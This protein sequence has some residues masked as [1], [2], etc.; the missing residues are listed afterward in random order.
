[1]VM[2]RFL[3]PKNDFAF[4]KI[5]G[6]EKNKEILIHFL[7]DILGFTK[8]QKIGSVTF[9]SPLQDPEA[10]AKKQS[11]VDVL[12]QDQTGRKFIIEMQVARVA[13]F[14]E[15]AQYYAARAYIS[16]MKVGGAYEDLAEVIFVAIMDH[17]IFPDKR[18]Y[19]SDH[20]IRDAKSNERD[21]DKLRFVFIEL[22]KFTKAIDELSSMVDKWYY[23]L[24]NAPETT[25]EEVEKLVDS[26]QIIKEAYTALNS[27][28]WN[29]KELLAYDQEMKSELDASAILK[30]S[31]IDGIAEGRAEGK[32][33]GKAEG[34]KTKA[35]EIAKKLK[36][37]KMPLETI[38]SITGLPL[39]ELENLM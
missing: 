27:F 1:M 36:A 7:N 19:Q 6:T 5:F 14:K 9:I 28:Y 4:K 35:L 29:D 21:L 2:P 16:Q 30:Q 11:I 12:C 22:P 25:P 13:G 3:D 20:T 17:V 37:S 10:L 34:E 31:R 33:E 15:R 26:D 23:F 38:Q 39:A 32:A 8:Q 18:C 24:K